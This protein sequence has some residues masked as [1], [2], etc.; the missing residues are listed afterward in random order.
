MHAN[1]SAHLT[2]FR[3][4]QPKEVDNY[5]GGEKKVC[6]L[7]C[8]N[9]NYGDSRRNGNEPLIHLPSY[10]SANTKTPTLFM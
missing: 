9:L 5:S 2:K 10:F 3:E 1:F 4:R 6:G 7:F 8:H